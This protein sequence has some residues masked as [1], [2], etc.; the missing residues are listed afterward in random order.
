MLMRPENNSSRPARGILKRCVTVLA[1]FALVIMMLPVRTGDV[2]AYDNTMMTTRYDVDVVVSENNSY[3]YS[4]SIDMYYVT[5][6]HG[7]YRYIPINGSRISNIKVP[8]YSYETY[9]QSGNTVIKIGSGSYT[10]TGPASYNITYNLAM[11]DDE[12]EEKDMLLLNLIPTGWT[13]DIDSTTCT[14]TLPKEADLSKAQVYSGSYGAEGNEDNV[15]MT[16]SDDGRTITVTGKSI[17]ANHGI[18]V[19]LE[20]PQG[21]WVGA[22]EFDKLR[23]LNILMFL[24]GPAGAFL[25][26]W[27]YGRDRKLVR[28]V[29]FYPPDGLTPGEIGYIVDG[30]VDERDTIST[31]VYLADKG[32][33]TI[34]DSG[35]KNFIF[36]AVK[37][38]S[39]SEPLY[40]RTIYSGL[41]AKS[42]MVHSDKL[43]TY[44]GRKYATARD[45]LKRMFEGSKSLNHPDSLMARAVCTIASVVPSAA[46]VTW[47]DTNGDDLGS[48]G[49]IWAAIHIV[50]TTAIMC[51]VYDKVRSNSKVKT[52][53]LTLAAIWFFAA[54]VGFLPLASD[55]LNYL[56][57]TKAMMVTGLLLISTLVC[58]FFAVIA[59]ARRDEYTILLGRILGFKDFIKTAELDKLNELVEEDP[60]YFYHIMPYAYVFGLSNKWIK[61]PITI[62]YC[63]NFGKRKL[64]DYSGNLNELRRDLRAV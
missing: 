13:T 7:I 40:V 17:P 29:E 47:A 5:A 3:A 53:V 18:T 21:Y 1:V 38:P 23:S 39:A 34:E 36:R 61:N 6:H 16:T 8:G 24:L 48:F 41:F 49:V 19:A 62:T 4:E 25:M 32:Y 55:A 35:R 14:V 37:E 52:V 63:N 58:I 42:T 44:F 30:V 22:P 2:Y 60:Q 28:T 64:C 57:S 46:F 45:Q 20:L 9:T 26:W 27:F 31:I 54:G 50:I 43:G 59:V 51:S 56:S 10:L 15:T 11:Y 12:N 33:I